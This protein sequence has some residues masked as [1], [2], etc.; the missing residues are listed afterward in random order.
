MSPTTAIPP[1]PPPTPPPV[2]NDNDKKEEKNEKKV[3][4]ANVYFRSW[5]HD[6]HNVCIACDEDIC[7][8][9]LYFDWLIGKFKGHKSMYR[10]PESEMKRILYHEYELVSN[11]VQYVYER[12]IGH[13]KYPY[14]TRRR[15]V[16]PQC[17]EGMVEN[18]VRNEYARQ[19]R[20]WLWEQDIDSRVR[21][22]GNKRTYH[23]FNDA[24]EAGSTQLTVGKE[25]KVPQFGEDEMKEKYED[26][27]KAKVFTRASDSV[28]CVFC[29]E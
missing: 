25:H 21:M 23:K 12:D 6:E 20:D 10:V 17:L 3:E 14:D 27:V 2:D 7:H 22:S 11:F 13:K 8:G 4:T 18:W 19:Y 16:V 24:G 28:R 1:S 9:T 5:L 29:S 15:R 26:E